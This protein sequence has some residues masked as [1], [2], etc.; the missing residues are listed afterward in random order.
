MCTLKISFKKIISYIH[1]PYVHPLTY[2]LKLKIKHKKKRRKKQKLMERCVQFT[3]FSSFFLPYLSLF[4]ITLVHMWSKKA[5][6]H[7]CILC[8]TLLFV[9]HYKVDLMNLTVV[10]VVVV[11]VVILV[12]HHHL[13]YSYFCSIFLYVF[14]YIRLVVLATFN[15]D[16][17]LFP[18]SKQ[19]GL[20]CCLFRSFT[21]YNTTNSFHLFYC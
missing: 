15:P 10:V 20:L 4:R 17:C 7:V 9:L 16:V 14:T 13:L 12:F 18:Y 11:D 1:I 3:S 8:R 5:D 21:L 6:M 2:L 19:H